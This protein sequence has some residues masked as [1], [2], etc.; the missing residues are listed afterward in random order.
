MK[1]DKL[2]QPHP[3]LIEKFRESPAQEPLEILKKNWKSIA[4]MSCGACC[5]SSVVPILRMDFDAFHQRLGLN[6]SLEDFA[7]MFLQIPHTV[8]P[9]CHIETEK[10][11][12]RCMFLEKREFFRCGV[13]D[14]KPDVC[15]EFFCWDMTIFEQ[16]MNAEDQDVF[17]PD[18]SW[19]KNFNKLLMRTKM[20]SP[21]S[22]FEDE[23]RTYLGLLK[24]DNYKSW[25]EAHKDRFGL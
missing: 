20:E 10:Y 17:P 1:I 24:G 7:K 9:S 14:L 3:Q 6:K 12:N 18:D 19:E 5:C 13:W 4:C 15:T 11:G 22:F 23:M 25:F 8:G 21:L 16:Y 2:I